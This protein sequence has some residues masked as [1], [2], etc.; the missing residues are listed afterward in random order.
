VEAMAA[1]LPAVV[2]DWDGYR[3]TVRDGIDGFRIPTRLPP[4]PA[5]LSVAAQYNERGGF[6]Q[7]YGTVAMS[8]AVDL[9]ACAEALARLIRD[10]G[11]R[12]RMGESGRHH[13]RGA[14]DWRTIMKTYHR[15]WQGLDEVRRES[16]MVAPLS[17][18]RA[19]YPLCD[20]PFRVF[21]KHATRTIGAE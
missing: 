2:S 11:L 13:A 9:D 14:Y 16:A 6:R 8:T 7:Y 1:G 17:P 5:G 12:H 21:E 3:D 18:G 20:D 10:P 19:P 15:F 4:P